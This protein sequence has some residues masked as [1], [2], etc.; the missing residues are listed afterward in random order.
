MDWIDYGFGVMRCKLSKKIK[1]GN[2]INKILFS[3]F[4][5]ISDENFPFPLVNILECVKNC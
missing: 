5:F 3:I 1:I 4:T 2:Y